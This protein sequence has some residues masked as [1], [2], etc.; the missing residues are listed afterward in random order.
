MTATDHKLQPPLRLVGGDRWSDDGGADLPASSMQ[1]AEQRLVALDEHARS[2]I[3]TLE[4]RVQSLEALLDVA[5]QRIRTLEALTD[6]SQTGPIAPADAVPTAPEGTDHA[7][8]S[9]LTS[10]ANVA[11]RSTGQTHAASGSHD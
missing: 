8:T 3:C 1:S 6:P 11:E 4:N 2:I 10:M 9:R 5:D 7:E